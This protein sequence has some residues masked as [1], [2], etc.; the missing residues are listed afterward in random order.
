MHLLLIRFVMYVTWQHFALKRAFSQFYVLAAAVLFCFSTFVQYLQICFQNFVLSEQ[1]L[2]ARL[3]CFNDAVQMS[4]RVSQPW[5]VR[6]RQYVYIWML[7][8]SFWSTLQSH[9][10]MITWWDNDWHSKETTIAI[11]L[12]LRSEFT[13][14]LLHHIDSIK[15][16][17]LLNESYRTLIKNLYDYRSVMMFITDIEIAAQM[18]YIKDLLKGFHEWRVCM[19]KISLIWQLNKE[20]KIS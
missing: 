15:L 1:W 8:V 13:E 6:V 17:V 11:L 7:R 16:F 18:S 10:F 2:A 19:K 4:I 9:P 3:H 20:S 5:H 12:K 14:K